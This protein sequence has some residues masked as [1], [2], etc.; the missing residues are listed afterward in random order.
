MGFKGAIPLLFFYL[1]PDYDD[2]DFSA[3]NPYH[4]TYMKDTHQPDGSSWDRGSYPH[5]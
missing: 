4:L 2:Y 5:L 1:D 3:T